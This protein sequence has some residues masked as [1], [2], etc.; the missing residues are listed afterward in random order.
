MKKQMLHIGDLSPNFNAYIDNGNNITLNEFQGK[1][2]VLYFYP[3]DETPGCTVEAKEFS[4]FIQYFHKI[5]TMILGVSK[6]SVESH[7]KFI[8]NNNLLFNLISDVEQSI[9]NK[10][11]V[12]K[13]KKMFGKTYLGIERSTFLIDKDGY[14]KYIW[15]NVKVMGH[16]Q[17][18]LEE[19]KKI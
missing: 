12:I 2:V 18:V 10:Y 19:A 6:D 9:C 13:E 7:D 5:N 8:K 14:I 3:K 16:V 15:R 11:D 4:E 1:N 17:N